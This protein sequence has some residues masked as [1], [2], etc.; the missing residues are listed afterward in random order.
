MGSTIIKLYRGINRNPDQPCRYYDSVIMNRF[1][2]Q[3]LALMILGK[4]YYIGWDVGAWHCKKAKGKSCDAIAILDGSTGE[5][6][7]CLGTF[8]ENL[9][10][11]II[12]SSSLLGWINILAEKCEPKIANTITENDLVTIAI[13]ATL[14]FPESMI[15][16]LTDRTSLEGVGEFSKDNQYLFRKTEKR[17][18]DLGFTPLSAIKDMIGSQSTKALHIIGKFKINQNSPG[19]W[20][21][22]NIT[23]IE[24]YPS[25]CRCSETVK[26]LKIDNE[27]CLQGQV[28]KDILDAITCARLACLYAN[29]RESLVKPENDISKLEGWIWVPTDCNCKALSA[30]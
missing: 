26:A 24:T 14:G 15:K 25:A 1:F 13:D 18:F 9:R 8:R 5:T 16:L 11:T 4:N 21:Q 2:K 27:G 22:G 20:I 6:L 30:T 19:I 7:Q 23:I 17:L 29:Q 28:Q 12:T 3:G 10:E